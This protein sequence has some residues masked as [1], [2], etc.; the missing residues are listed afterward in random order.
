MT[1]APVLDH[2][3]VL[4]DP[5]RARLLAV[6][7]GHELTV[8]ELCDV[9]QLPQSTV[10]RHLKTLGDGGWVVSRRDGTS[11]FYSLA[12]D[13]ADDAAARLWDL[14]REHVSQTPAASQDGRRLQGV[15]LGRRRKSEEFF[16]ST[17]GQWDRLRD[18]LFGAASHLRPLLA[19]VART[20]WSATSAAALVR[21]LRPWR[22]SF[23]E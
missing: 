19:L 6:L 7:D 1:T 21:W 12:L 14:V 9:L 13:G 20:G 11:R 2:L 3:A 17:A 23:A 15:L 4:A 8:S 18:D 10:S 5:L 16:S 22:R